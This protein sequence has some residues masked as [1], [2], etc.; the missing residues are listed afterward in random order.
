MRQ[1]DYK[2]EAQN[3]YR[4]K[5]FYE[6]YR[7]AWNLPFNEFVKWF[8][9]S[10]GKRKRK[11]RKSKNPIYYNSF[12]YNNFL[13]TKRTDWLNQKNA[14][15][16]WQYY[17]R[18]QK[19][20][21]KEFELYVAH[22]NPELFCL[23]YKYEK[24][25]LNKERIHFIQCDDFPVSIKKEL[26][27]WYTIFNRFE[28]S[29]EAI[30][31][32]F[33]NI[34]SKP[35]RVLMTL[36]ASFE[37]F[38]FKNPNDN[39]KWQFAGE[40]LSWL[41]A[42]TQ[43]K[44]DLKSVKVAHE[45]LFKI[46]FD[47]VIFNRGQKLFSCAYQH[48]LL[49]DHINRYVF[50]PGLKVTI[51]SKNNLI[52]NESRE[53]NEQ[54]SNDELR[55]DVNEQT[56]YGFGEIQYADFKNKN[57]IKF[58]NDNL[59]SNNMQGNTRQ[60]AI[61]QAVYDLGI[62]DED[63]KQRDIPALDAIIS[64]LHG[65]AWQKFKTI[66]KPFLAL[67]KTGIK[68]Y[69]EAVTKLIKEEKGAEL[70]LVSRKEELFNAVIYAG[71]DC[72]E[73]GFYKLIDLFSYQGKRGT[74]QKLSQK[75]SLWQKPFIQIGDFIISPFSVLTSFTGLYTISESILRNF[76]PQNGRRIETQLVEMYKD[77]NWK[78]YKKSNNQKYG[79]VDVVMEDDYDIILMQLKRTT[80]KTNT[81][82]LHNQ[83][84]QD[85]EA[86]RQLTE[87]KENTK[88]DKKIH[89]WY[90]T[91]ALEKINTTMEGVLRVSYQDLVNTKRSMEIENL[92][93]NSLSHF[94]QFVEEDTWC[95]N[96]KSNLNN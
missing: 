5:E 19:E 55:Y 53:F 79:D 60:L 35:Q 84:S 23:G 93:F 66:E 95:N 7:T 87:A 44:Y 71:I 2:R 81:L 77:E 70:V 29:K 9:D 68:S 65:I 25:F 42:I 4:N 36:L 43:E 64:F 32:E 18:T 45:K 52:F 40:A 76:Q 37:T 31:R 27:I 38:I 75:V 89:L 86:I 61:K 16:L 24:V 73:Q 34:E 3:L 15:D 11:K 96:G 48:I 69:K 56:Y 50:E 21:I 41:V 54:W 82:E 94:I 59:T 10:S 20:P 62:R 78:T 6:A 26:E 67:S 13:I 80:Q 33:T 12:F 85:R 30:K 17:L 8:T 47:S 57:K 72:E 49:L 88:L 1:L 90:V 51:D 39:V 92:N 22:N 74:I 14:L 28:A 83:T 63:L 58:I 91:T 46:Y